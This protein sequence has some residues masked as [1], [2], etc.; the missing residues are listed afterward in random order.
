MAE[1]KRVVPP[2][3]RRSPAVPVEVHEYA[4]ESGCQLV[5]DGGLSH[6][7]FRGSHGDDGHVPKYAGLH[8]GRQAGP[9]RGRQDNMQATKRESKEGCP[10]ANVSART[11]AT[12]Q[13][14][15]HACMQ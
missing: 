3:A 6:A 13:E 15:E 2:H 14:G 1:G 7:S 4:P 8:D 11:P 10:R 5:G 12:W 9:Q